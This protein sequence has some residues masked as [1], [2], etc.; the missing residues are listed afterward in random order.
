MLYKAGVAAIFGP[1]LCAD[2]SKF[3]GMQGY[4]PLN[5]F[6]FL[7]RYRVTNSCY[8]GGGSD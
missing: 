7:F 5:C 4:I 6:I 3:V 8:E 2:Y 1:G